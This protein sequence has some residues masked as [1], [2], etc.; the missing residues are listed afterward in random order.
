MLR[1]GPAVAEFGSASSIRI[2]R[3]QK[4]IAESRMLPEL[5]RVPLLI[6]NLAFMAYM[7]AACVI[8]GGS[9]SAGVAG[10]V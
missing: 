7:N 1:D 3:L 4:G 5:G 6:H 8:E 9:V 10:H 2:V